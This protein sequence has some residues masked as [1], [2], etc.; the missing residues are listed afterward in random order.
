MIKKIPL[1]TCVVTKEKYPKSELLRV[2]K[3]NTGNVFID[4][5]GKANGRG[6]YLKKD[7]DVIKKARISKQLDRHLEITVSDALYDELE[8]IVNM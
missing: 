2:V 5:T 6:A 3:D 7:I 4:K 1:R 8:T